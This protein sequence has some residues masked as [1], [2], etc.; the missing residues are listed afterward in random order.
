MLSDI[1]SAIKSVFDISKIIKNDKLKS[2]MLMLITLTIVLVKPTI[3][4]ANLY[5]GFCY[6]F[7]AVFAILFFI[8]IIYRVY[9]NK[10]N[11]DYHNETNYTLMG[12][13]L[14]IALI[15]FIGIISYDY[16]WGN[17]FFT[18]KIEREV[19]V[20]CIHDLEYFNVFYSYVQSNFLLVL[21]YT[22][23]FTQTLSV[24][25]FILYFSY[26]LLYTK[27]P[28]ELGF[29]SSDWKTMILNVLI[30]VFTSPIWFSAYTTLWNKI[31]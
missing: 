30:I 8:M 23:E 10:T 7:A 18:E 3:Y 11:T 16:V 4:Y 19:F 6:L 21:L 17:I 12:F 9:C 27:S 24:L 2:I 25:Y 5:I 14:I 22:I 28:L 15:L 31:F 1:L 13:F 26:K 29:T 20:K